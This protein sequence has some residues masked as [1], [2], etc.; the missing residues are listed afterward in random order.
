MADLHSHQRRSNLVQ[1]GIDVACLDD[2]S[3]F[4]FATVSVNGGVTHLQWRSTKV[5]ITM[6]RYLHYKRINSDT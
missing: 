2:T 1:Y 4:D 5:W 3:P 6:A